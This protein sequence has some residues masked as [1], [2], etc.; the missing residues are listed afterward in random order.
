MILIFRRRI[1]AYIPLWDVEWRCCRSSHTFSITKYLDI[2]MTSTLVS[3]W[4]PRSGLHPT[5]NI[6]RNTKANFITPPIITYKNI[7][8]WHGTHLKN[9]KIL[10]SSWEKHN[11]INHGHQ[12]PDATTSAGSGADMMVPELTC[13]GIEDDMRPRMSTNLFCKAFGQS[14]RISFDHNL[15]S[16]EDR[17]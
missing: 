2:D 12:Q 8:S 5:T 15:K 14:T 3:S 7:Y 17:T 11:L 6:S 10:W 9:R 13:L 16:D 4:L 1:V